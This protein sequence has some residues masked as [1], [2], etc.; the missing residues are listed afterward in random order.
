MSD[1]WLEP[2]GDSAC[3]EDLE[4]DNDFLVLA[5]AAA[6]KPETQFSEAQ[7]PDWRQVRTLAEG[8]FERTRDLRVAILWT[9][10][11]V[12]L[13]GLSTLP[14]SLTLM[15]GLLSRYWDELYPLPDPDDGDAYARI[16]AL[17]EMTSASS[18]LGDIRQGFIFR[19]RAIGELRGRDVEIALGN[20]EPRQDDPQ[21]GVPQVE[22]LLSAALGEDASL[23]A[24]AP[25]SMAA[26]E[27]LSGLMRDKVGYERAPS[28]DTLVSFFKGL[29]RVMPSGGGSAGASD[30]AAAG[31]PGGSSSDDGAVAAVA[32]RAGGGAGGGGLGS[33]IDTR[34]DA[35]RAIEMVCSYLERTEPTNPAQLLLRRASKLV[36]KNFLELVRE[37]APDA[38]STVANVMG[39]SPD[40][41]GDGQ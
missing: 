24:I 19:Q 10:A 35:L 39:V 41:Y 20:I 1:A 13:D 28:F 16:N 5:Q 23:A 38:F 11:Q 21:M 8:L 12:N 31:A 34:A 36:N 7:P 25:D 15:H 4:Y 9:R 29:A 14:A 33:R 40:E 18:L 27:N 17:S 26:L 32:G 22:Q 3:G 37:F 6:G 30:A 2:L